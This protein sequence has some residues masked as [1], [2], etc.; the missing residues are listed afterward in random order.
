M[1]A[2][3]IV[4]AVLAGLDIVIGWPVAILI[5][6]LM[7]RKEIG[8]LFGMLGERLWRISVGGAT[9]EF[10]PSLR[11]VTMARVA[12]ERVDEPEG[13]ASEINEYNQEIDRL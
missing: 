1:T 9:A 5:V 3:E 2:K 10:S 8:H 13:D 11:E 4:D 7:L 6:V 12:S